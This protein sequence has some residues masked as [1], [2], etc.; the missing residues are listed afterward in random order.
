M[1]GVRV[2]AHIAQNR[3]QAHYRSVNGRVPCSVV[4]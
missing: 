1:K 3:R 4:R 2:L